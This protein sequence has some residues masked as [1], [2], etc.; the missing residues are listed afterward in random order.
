[1]IGGGVLLA[2]GV[3]L[4]LTAPSNAPST[5]GT[6]RALRIAAGPTPG[7]GGMSLGGEF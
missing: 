2:G 7:G 5:T 6:V 1:M 4:Y 3:V